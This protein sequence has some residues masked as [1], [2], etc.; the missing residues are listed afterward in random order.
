MHD[1]NAAFVEHAWLGPGV[2]KSWSSHPLYLCY[3]TGSVLFFGPFCGPHSQPLFYQ[4]WALE[5]LHNL[6][7]FRGMHGK[8]G[9][10]AN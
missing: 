10:L 9:I 4:K 2:R 7:V 8:L 1:A 6:C 3:L 5:T